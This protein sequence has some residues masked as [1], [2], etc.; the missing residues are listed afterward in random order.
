MILVYPRFLCIAALSI[1]PSA[2]LA[3]TAT[4]SFD[5]RI[6]IVAECEIASAGDLDFGSTGVLSGA[7]QA[8][9]E[10]S[11]TCTTSTPYQ[12]GLNAGSG[13]GATVTNRL[14]TGPG[15]ATIAYGLFRDAGGSLNWGNTL[16]A[17]VVASTGTGAAQDFTVYGQVL[18]Q[19]TPAPGTYT[20]TITVTVTY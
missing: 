11:V 20:D 16:G 14:M 18:A 6:S 8:S 12:I 7:T 5:V 17:D 2:I 13:S 19:T 15:G 3:Q 10:I 4:D 9:S 1:F